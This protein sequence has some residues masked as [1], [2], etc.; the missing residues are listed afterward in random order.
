MHLSNKLNSFLNT[1]QIAR[2]LRVWWI[3]SGLYAGM[4]IGLGVMIAWTRKRNLVSAD[5]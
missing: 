2:F 1:E 3:H 4:A 5:R